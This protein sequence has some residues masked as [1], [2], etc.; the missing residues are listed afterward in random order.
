MLL[1]TK[2]KQ[3]L[4]IVLCLVFLL[5]LVYGAIAM[6]AIPVRPLFADD[7]ISSQFSVYLPVLFREMSLMPLYLPY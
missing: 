2:V 4:D 1:R 6:N 7:S 5:A 3:N